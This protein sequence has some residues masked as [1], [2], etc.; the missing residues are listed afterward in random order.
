MPESVVKQSFAVSELLVCLLLLPNNSVMASRR[1]YT[2]CKQLENRPETVS[3]VDK[4]V[5]SDSIFRSD[6]ASKTRSGLRAICLGL[7]HWSKVAPF[8]FDSATDSGQALKY[9]FV[10]LDLSRQ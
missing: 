2:D 1:I 6:H 10:L 5:R 3:N 4:T 9:T 8:Y 7:S